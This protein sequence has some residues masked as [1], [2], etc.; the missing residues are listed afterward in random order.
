MPGFKQHLLYLGH[1]I[2]EEGIQQLLDK[3]MAIT[4]DTEPR[5]IDEL[6]QFLGLTQYYG[7][8]IPLSPDISKLFNKLLRKDTKF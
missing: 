5:Y 8:I 6:C 3:T 4:N 2:S 1:S 7:R